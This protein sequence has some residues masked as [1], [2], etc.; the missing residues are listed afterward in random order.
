MSGRKLEAE[1]V[2]VLLPPGSPYL[3]SASAAAMLRLLRNVAA[4]QDEPG[5]ENQR[6]HEVGERHTRRV[7]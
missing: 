5:L 2:R 4:V 6:E 7:A 3:T 1:P